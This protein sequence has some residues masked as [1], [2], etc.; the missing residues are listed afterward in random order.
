MFSN[1]TLR[2]RFAQDADDVA[3]PATLT[4]GTPSH[5]GMVKAID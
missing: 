3:N 5:E 2:G 1:D 4:K